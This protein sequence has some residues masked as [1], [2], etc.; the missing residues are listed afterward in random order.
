MEAGAALEAEGRLDEALAEYSKAAEADPE[1]A[2]PHWAMAQ[3]YRRQQRAVEALTALQRYVALAPDGRH[4]DTARQQMDALRRPTGAPARPVGAR[5]APRPPTSGASTPARSRWVE[6]QWNLACRLE[7][8]ADYD[9]A[10]R[11]FGYIL[12][13]EPNFIG[14]A[15][16]YEH[17]AFCSLGLDPPEHSRAVH[18]LEEAAKEYRRLGSDEEAERCLDLASRQEAYLRAGRAEELA[19]GEAASPPPPPVAPQAIITEEPS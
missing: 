12:T 10:R 17:M 8:A 15:R 3:V 2:E 4:A 13:R 11:A 9:R 5:Q 16:V 14:K 1:A 18:Y 7:A 19:P 6:G